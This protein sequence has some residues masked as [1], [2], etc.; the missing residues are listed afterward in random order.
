MNIKRK[1]LSFVEKNYFYLELLMLFISLY[2]HLMLSIVTPT[3]DSVYF[4]DIMTKL[5]T[6]PF[7]GFYVN[8]GITYPS[9]FN[10]VYYLI[11]RSLLAFGVPLIW[12]NRI[13]VFAVKFPCICAEFAMTA[14]VYRTAKKY[15]TDI[16]RRLLLLFL[17][18]F[19][20]GYLFVT[21]YICQVDALYTFF[22]LLTVYLIMT[23]HLKASYFSFAAGILFK[24]QTVFI[25]PILILGIIK[26][27]ILTDFSWKRFFSHL[28]TGLF[29]ICC[30]IL[31]YIPFIYDFG[32]TQLAD[33]GLS[34][35]LT[36]SVIGYSRA[37]TNAY[38]FWTLLGYNLKYDSNYWGPF[39][40]RTWGTFFI[41]LLVIVCCILFFQ[42]KEN[43]TIYPA[44]AALLV[45]GIFCFSMR[46]MSR[47][48]YPAI[49]LLFLACAKKPS[50][51]RYISAI[52]FSL[53]FFAN[54]WC[55]YMLYPY[56][57]YHT[58]LVLPYVLSAFMLICFGY[59]VYVLIREK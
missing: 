7:Y 22:V 14:L 31:S 35:N 12:Q 38:N 43:P 6:K 13:F 51:Q 41:V 33:G 55:D 5:T 3:G 53:S 20:P 47:Y 56:T 9:L 39:T 48:L 52:L 32:H 59:S 29:A 26:Q 24:F 49:I 45:S 10:Y 57:A 36:S 42:K 34:S 54:V 40:C 16:F 4:S 28:F 15:V 21:A 44:L 23:E 19:N 17:L 30:M 50:K 58:D 18:L 46:M 11:A 2:L 1:I 27:V 8:A 37:S 25:G